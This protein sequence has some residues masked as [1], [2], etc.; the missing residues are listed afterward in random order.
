M[1][2]AIA[3]AIVFTAAPALAQVVDTP[4]QGNARADLMNAP[5]NEQVIV[6]ASLAYVVRDAR[7]FYRFQTH[8]VC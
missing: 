6:A 3:L 2:K 8:G 4:E 5:Q 7:V 1:L